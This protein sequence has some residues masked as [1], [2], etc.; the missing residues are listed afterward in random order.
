MAYDNDPDRQA[1]P[2]LGVLA[3]LLFCLPLLLWWLH[4]PVPGVGRGFRRGA[5]PV[6]SYVL[7][8]AETAQD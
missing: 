7:A 8:H 5:G 2:L 3:V 4:G 6:V 1:Q